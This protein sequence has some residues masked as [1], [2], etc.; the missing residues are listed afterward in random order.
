V[1]DP[2]IRLKCIELAMEQ[3]KREQKHGN[4]QAIA[5]IT[6]YLYNLTQGNGNS[7]VGEQPTVGK[8]NGVVNGRVKKPGADKSVFD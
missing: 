5:E 6:S 7:A 8:T 2:E 3:A 4:R 1:T